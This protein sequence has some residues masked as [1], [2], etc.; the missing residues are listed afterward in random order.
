MKKLLIP[1][2]I[3]MFALAAC[4]PTDLTALGDSVGTMAESFTEPTTETDDS[5]D[6]DSLDDSPS[7]SSPSNEM[8]DESESESYSSSES[9]DTYAVEVLFEDG[10]SLP[11]T[12]TLHEHS[13]ISWTNHDTVSYTITIVKMDDSSDSD[14]SMDDSSDSSD[15]DSEMDDTATHTIASN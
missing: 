1:L 13:Q 5:S 11:E 7:D 2:V 3:V 10:T 4:E 8:E 14:S 6:D 15:S 12:L 9:S